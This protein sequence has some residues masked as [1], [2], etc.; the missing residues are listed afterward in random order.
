MSDNSTISQEG[1]QLPTGSAVMSE[2]P[3]LEV[4]ATT[5][6]TGVSKSPINTSNCK[7]VIEPID[8]ARLNKMSSTSLQSLNL[9]QSQQHHKCTHSKD[10][11]DVVVDVPASFSD[12]FKTSSKHIPKDNRKR[13]KVCHITVKGN[14]GLTLHL[15]SNPNC[16]RNVSSSKK[17]RDRCG[18]GG[19]CAGHC[20]TNFSG[21]VVDNDMTVVV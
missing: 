13:C 17:V 18:C 5:S 1:L 6:S 10:K 16:R 19:A 12:R 11:C 15:N 20:C 3:G 9:F 2:P 14:R 8:F 21:N 7:V 4:Q